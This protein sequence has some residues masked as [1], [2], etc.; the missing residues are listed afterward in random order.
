MFPTKKHTRRHHRQHYRKQ[1]L[2]YCLHLVGGASLSGVPGK[3]DLGLLGRRLAAAMPLLSSLIL[4][5]PAGAGSER[6]EGR[7]TK[8]KSKDE[9]AGPAACGFRKFSREPVVECRC[10]MDLLYVLVLFGAIL[11]GIFFLLRGFQKHPAAQTR[12]VDQPQPSNQ[13]ISSY[14]FTASITVIQ[15]EAAGRK[16]SARVAQAILYSRPGT[17]E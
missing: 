11:V 9:R 3:P 8:G 4:S 12:S 14:R 15:M 6:C 5:E 16:L 7:R 13:D 2:N 1:S 17:S 10:V